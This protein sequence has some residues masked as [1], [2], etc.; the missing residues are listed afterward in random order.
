MVENTAFSN[1][2]TKFVVVIGYGDEGLSGICLAEV[3]LAFSLHLFLI[4][5]TNTAPTNL[6]DWPSL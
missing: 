5:F 1:L 2:M 6:C 3:L 4:S